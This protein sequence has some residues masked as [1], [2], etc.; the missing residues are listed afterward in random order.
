MLALSISTIDLHYG[1]AQALKGVSL[2]CR[3]GK[4]T[5]VLGRNGVGKSST[6]RAITGINHIS[7][8]G[9]PQTG[10]LVSQLAAENHVPVTLELLGRRMVGHSIDLDN[11]LGRREDEVADADGALAVD[12]RGVETGD[13]DLRK[14]WGVGQSAATAGRTHHRTGKIAR[15]GID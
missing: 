4:I 3:P 5:A 2:D 8:T 13:R 1:A 7:F 15:R 11:D 12:D 9:S 10:K 6:L 14:R